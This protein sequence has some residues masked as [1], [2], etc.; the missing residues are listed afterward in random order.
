MCLH[1]NYTSRRLA[2]GGDQSLKEASAVFRPP[3]TIAST[4]QSSGRA[5]NYKTDHKSYHK[6]FVVCKILTHD[7]NSNSVDKNNQKT[8]SQIA[9]W[10]VTSQKGHGPV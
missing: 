6:A 5:D 10:T 2:R 4:Q 8:G 1:V 3:S 7:K 9:F